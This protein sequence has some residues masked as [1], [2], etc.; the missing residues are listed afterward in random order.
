MKKT[1]RTNL[2]KMRSCTFLFGLLLIYSNVLAKSSSSFVDEMSSQSVNQQRETVKGVVKDESGELMIGAEVVNQRT[3]GGT[4]T[5]IDGV[6]QV[7]CQIGDKLR[8]TYLGYNSQV[9]TVNS[10]E[11]LVI[12]LE[13]NPNMMQEVVITGMGISRQKKT[14]GYSAQ[15]VK[16]EE[17]M[18]VRPTSVNNALV[19]KVSGMRF[20]TNAGSS[21]N[22]ASLVLR[23]T[24]SLELG[25]VR[26]LS[27]IYV[28]DGVIAAQSAVNMDDVESI[29][30]LKGPAAT[31][32]Y[33]SRGGYGAIIITTKTAKA[34]Y[35]EISVSNTLMFDTYYRHADL[36]SEYGGG[37][38]ASAN[39]QA[40]LRQYK[41]EPGPN[42]NPA[43]QKLDGAYYYNMDSP[44]QSW[45]PK[46]NKDIQY[47]PWYAWDPIDPR[48]GK[49]IPWMSASENV[50]NEGLRTAVTNTTN[51]SFAKG[52][53]DYTTRVSFSNSYRGGM[54]PNSDLTKRYFSMRTSFNLLKRLKIS[55]D[56]KYS[57]RKTHNSGTN[58]FL[59]GYATGA[60]RDLSIK[61]LKNYK[62]TD[63]SYNSYNIKDPTTEGD[64]QIRSNNPF[65]S[66]NALNDIYKYHWNLLRATA[67]FVITPKMSAF[68]IYNGGINNWTRKYELAKGLYGTIPQFFEQQVNYTDIQLQ[69]QF[70]YKDSAI[71]NKLRWD[72]NVFVE[73]RDYNYESLSG[74]TNGGLLV[75]GLYNFVGSVDKATA[76][77]S[78][79]QSQNKSLF[80]T[81][82]VSWDDTYFAE[83]SLR[84]DWSSTL[85]KNNH[86]YLYGGASLSYIM[87]NH[88]KQ[89]WLDFLKIRASAAQVGSTM[90]AYQALSNY[91]M[92][93]FG[94]LTTMGQPSKY[95]DR[96]LKP[97]I[98]TS[99]EVGTEFTVLKGLLSADLNFYIRD[100]KNQI[101]NVPVSHQ[102]GYDAMRTNAGLIRNKGFELTL[103][104]QFINTKDFKWSLSFNISKNVNSLVELSAT[105][106]DLK[107]YQQN[108]ASYGDTFIVQWA[109]VGAPVGVLRGTDFEKV[110]GKILL[111]KLDPNSQ[112][113]QNTV[114]NQGEYQIVLNRSEKNYLGNSQPK[115]IGGF[116]TRVSY[117]DFTL[118]GTM[119]FQIGG[120]LASITNMRGDANGML[121]STA[122]KNKDGVDK[123]NRYVDGGGVDVK[124]VVEDGVDASGNPIYKD[125]ETRIG[126]YYYYNMKR[127]VW[128]PNVY[129]ASYA[130]LREI[131]LSYKVPRSFLNKVSNDIKDVNLSFVAVNP[132]LIYSATPNIDPSDTAAG[133]SSGFMEG[134]SI[135]STRSFG[136]TVNVTF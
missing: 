31:A 38:L 7:E 44:G 65:T 75:D 30:I 80:G 92:G 32:L 69:G 115:A 46:F 118:S 1:K 132:W 91:S 3:R 54:V 114:D 108:Y 83:L 28:V 56:Y 34:G 121:A 81:A 52:G 14:L 15:E 40:G 99:Y 111:R 26:G 136:F 63:G 94:N 22:D 2:L 10:L 37:S 72:A 74:S 98:S 86:S 33:G 35:Q 125:V 11:S 61:D 13:E 87:S 109:E 129:D 16:S 62:R 43:F 25:N 124:G 29:N 24:T 77:N 59:A 27:P 51:I 48:F 41:Y 42:V 113:Y 126:T 21:F 79:T 47:A 78:T 119:D 39:G 6:F 127:Q 17:L 23:G 50:V 123:R 133:G 134:G 18:R 71:E 106:P 101:L 102:S 97:T 130:K 105:D 116:S 8:I 67:E 103:N 93:K 107:T 45:G 57:Y 12:T 66:M 68:F 131:A 76:S 120:K 96:N 55:A 5:D 58:G 104:S 84:N 128:G 36:Q 64:Y 135:L 70:S 90:S 100:S 95:I 88:L 9:V 49:T 112:G 85:P 122:G 53:E 20:L 73:Q 60:P 89:D 4:T 110:N 82:T 117:K 19:G